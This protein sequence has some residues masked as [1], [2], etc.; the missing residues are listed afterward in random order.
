M[1]TFPVLA[2]VAERQTKFVA[3]MMIIPQIGS[4]NFRPSFLDCSLSSA[5]R[6]KSGAMLMFVRDLVS[7]LIWSNDKFCLIENRFFL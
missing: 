6:A 1:R 4:K 2:A 7:L 5:I 3:V